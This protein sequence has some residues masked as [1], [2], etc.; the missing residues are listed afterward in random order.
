ML[1]LALAA[2]APAA[3]APGP[4]DVRADFVSGASEGDPASFN[5]WQYVASDASNPSAASNGLPVLTW[6]LPPGGSYVHTPDTFN[7]PVVDL[8]SPSLLPSEVRLHPSARVPQFA[9]LRWTAPAAGPVTIVGNVRKVDVGGGDGVTFEIFVDGAPLFSTALTFGDSVGVAFSETATLAVGSTV[10]FV[11]GPAG[12]EVNDSTALEASITPA[13][14]A[15]PLLL[16]PLLGVLA[17]GLMLTALGGL[18]RRR[19]IPRAAGPGRCPSGCP[20][21]P[22]P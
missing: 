17:G 3:A 1:A 7:L 19:A 8:L 18:A 21:G 22:A 13:A 12:G 15:V 14:A 16:P 10:D 6:F 9:A 5:G 11:V 2:A 4:A 20:R